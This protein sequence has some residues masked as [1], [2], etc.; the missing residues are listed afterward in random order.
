M[1]T[2]NVLPGYKRVA[3][4]DSG[5]GFAT[6]A[7]AG[8]NKVVVM[9][10]NSGNSASSHTIVPG[11][12]FSAVTA[13]FV[14]QSN[15]AVFTVNPISQSSTSITIN[16]PASAVGAIVFTVGGSTVP[17]TTRP[18]TTTSASRTTVRTT[19]TTAA[20]SECAARWGQCGGIG[21][22]GPKCCVSG[23]TCKFSN[24]WVRFLGHLDPS[25]QNRV[26]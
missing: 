4:S 13:S 12:S 6:S 19:T 9:V 7:Y 1:W 3:V 26:C 14:S 23:T 11:R 5:S 15:Q 2:K 21:Y 20:P 17:T 24:D 25:A 8:G 10:T 16:V 18:A 22:T